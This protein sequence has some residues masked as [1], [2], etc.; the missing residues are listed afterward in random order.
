[1]TSSNKTILATCLLAALASTA[2]A[3]PATGERLKDWP[4]VTSAIGPDAALEARVQQI[5]AQMTLAQKVG[6]MTQPEIKM[7]TPD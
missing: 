4:R 7:I 2:G 3:A 6:Q 5:V 1:M